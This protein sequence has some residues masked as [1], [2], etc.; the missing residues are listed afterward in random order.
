[1]GPRRVSAVVLPIGLDTGET[2]SFEVWIVV[3]PDELG[4]IDLELEA[5]TG[6]V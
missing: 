5:A 4:K 3:H 6:A 1:M 2:A